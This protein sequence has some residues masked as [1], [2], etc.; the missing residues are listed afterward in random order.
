[1]LK[2]GKMLRYFQIVQCAIVTSNGLDVSIVSL[3]SYLCASI[4]T[5][6][7][8]IISTNAI[9]LEIQLRSIWFKIPLTQGW[10]A[11]KEVAKAK[12]FW[13][14]VVFEACKS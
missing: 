3:R 6:S 1:M 7:K 13:F 14:P 12:I 4:P 9:Q 8:F 11:G 2:I 10:C 5:N